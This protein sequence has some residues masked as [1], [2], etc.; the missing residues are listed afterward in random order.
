FSF[1]SGTG[2]FVVLIETFGSLTKIIQFQQIRKSQK[3]PQVFVRYATGL[4]LLIQQLLKFSH[5]FPGFSEA[6]EIRNIY[7]LCH[8]R[9]AGALHA[10]GELFVEVQTFSGASRAEV[11]FRQQELFLEIK[12]KNAGPLQRLSSY[13]QQLPRSNKG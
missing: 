4:F 2:K 8:F 9:I 5:C 3:A 13:A 10:G 7:E 6:P 12:R 11:F 1:F